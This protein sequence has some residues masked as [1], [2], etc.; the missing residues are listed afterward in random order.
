MQ[1]KTN[2]ATFQ[3]F[4][5]QH[6]KLADSTILQILIFFSACSFFL[7][8]G[9]PSVGEEG[10][11]TN[12]TLEMLYNNDYLTPTL[13]GVEY[14]RPPLF[15][16]LN[17]IVTK[18]IGAAH[19]VEAA[20]I[21]NM[22]A[23]LSTAGLLFW[24]V[25][26]IFAERKLA[27][28]TT[29]V[30]LSGDL[31]FKR[32]WLAY[33]DSLFSLCVFAAI[34][35][36]WLALERKQDRWFVVASLSLCAGFLAKV[37]TIYLFY[38]IA[39]LVLIFK[40]PH[41]SYIFR[42]LSWL[43]HLAALLF[44][45][46]WA[47]HVRG[48][49]SDIQATATYSQ[50]LFQWPGF[51]AYAFHVLIAYPINLIARFLPASLI[52]LIALAKR[53]PQQK[54][55]ANYKSIQIIF[56]L[57]VLNL[58]LYWLA[59]SS[60]IRY[61]LPM[62]PFISLLIAYVILQAGSKILQLTIKLLIAACVLKYLLAICW[63][64]YEHTVYRGNAFKIAIDILAQT[65]DQNLYINDSSSAGLR[66]AVELNKL[67]HNQ[68]PLTLVPQK[69]QGYVLTAEN[70]PKLGELRQIYKLRSSKLYL[71]FNAGSS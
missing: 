16:W 59:P 34:M 41:R 11:Y 60:T 55:T 57:V 33:A 68:E 64:P 69:F 53:N 5:T 46:A 61:I 9:L 50:G 56:W 31:L 28:L 44:P 26:N 52:A 58:L 18:V 32:G 25:H 36:L 37:H 24:F 71:L 35:S 3:G 30:Y 13:Y 43:M 49:F 29:A 48:G 12:I 63:L 47:M 42:P 15:N 54:N 66:V 39:G 17:L 21:V 40:H 2:T 27:L 4:S 7:T 14:Y 22:T 51:F 62:Y 70:D 38:T 20:R 67:R 8:L 65:K 45:F 6:K 1:L 23:T 10:V 19:V